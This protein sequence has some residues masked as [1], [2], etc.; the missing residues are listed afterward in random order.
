MG[1]QLACLATNAAITGIAAVETILGLPRNTERAVATGY[2]TSETDH[3]WITQLITWPFTGACIMFSML[4]Q[5][6]SPSLNRT[7]QGDQ[8]T[9]HRGDLVTVE[10]ATASHQWPCG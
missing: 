2:L 1:H 4:A 6:R 10:C 5:G 7:T 8:L 9:G 3:Q